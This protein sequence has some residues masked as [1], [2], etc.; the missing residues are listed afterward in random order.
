MSQWG[1]P[2][3]TPK[4]REET[5]TQNERDHIAHRAGQE[6]HPGSRRPGL[7]LASLFPPV[8]PGQIVQRL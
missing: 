4:C 6:A 3:S 5:E 1:A 8:C 7:E 2:G